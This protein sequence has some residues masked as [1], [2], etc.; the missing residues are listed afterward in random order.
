MVGLVWF[1]IL[2]FHH[3]LCRWYLGNLGI[4]FTASGRGDGFGNINVGS[5]YFLPTTMFIEGTGNHQPIIFVAVLNSIWKWLF[6]KD[7]SISCVEFTF[8]WETLLF[9]SDFADSCESE[10]YWNASFSQQWIDRRAAAH[11]MPSRDIQ[12]QRFFSPANC[13]NVRGGSGPG[14]FLVYLVG[15]HS[16]EIT[17]ANTSLFT[18][19]T[20]WLIYF[21]LQISGAKI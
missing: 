1:C 16:L 20:F 18:N 6:L 7:E 21:H 2:L 5:I 13:W 14:Q 4:C 19:S 3:G 9:C 8:P 17:V 12:M 15:P 10:T 11:L